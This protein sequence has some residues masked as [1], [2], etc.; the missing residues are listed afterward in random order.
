MPL[1][2]RNG[3]SIQ[4]A[5]TATAYNRSDLRDESRQLIDTIRKNYGESKDLLEKYKS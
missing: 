3:S 2:V 1:R 5:S 4:T